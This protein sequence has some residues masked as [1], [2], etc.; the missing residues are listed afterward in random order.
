[1]TPGEAKNVKF[2]GYSDMEGRKDAV[3]V[4]GY[5]NYL[6]VGHLWSGGVDI[7]NVSDP[8]NPKMV[9]YI[10]SHCCPGKFSKYNVTI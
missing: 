2:I 6:Y 4:V 8:K 1:M 9:S 3:Q 7:I 5:G 10:P